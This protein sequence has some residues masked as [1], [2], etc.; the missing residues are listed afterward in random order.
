LA[1]VEAFLAAPV[2]I[3][4]DRPDADLLALFESHHLS[5]APLR[6][7][8]RDHRHRLSAYRAR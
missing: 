7:E 8:R 6:A 2:D 4:D 3:G 1:T 5:W